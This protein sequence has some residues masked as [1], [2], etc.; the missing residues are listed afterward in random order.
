[1]RVTASGTIFDA[2][3]A[4]VNCRSCAFTSVARLADG[5]LLVA[6]RNAT[7]RDAPD[8]RLRVMRSRDT[9]AT[10]ETIVP[11]MTATVAGIEGNLYAGYLTEIAPAR[12]LGAF[13]WVDRSNPAL[14]FVNPV[15]TG[16]LPMRVLVA[17][18]PD[19]GETWGSFRTVDLAPHAGCSCTGPVMRLPGGR[20]ALPY[21]RWKEYDDAS[22]GEHG[23][24]LRFSGDG[25]G[26]WPGVATVATDPAARI[27]YWDQRIAVHPETGQLV[28]MFWTHD[29]QAEQDIETHIAWGTPD[30]SNWTVPRPTGWRGQHCEP[31]A[32][33]GDRLV[34]VYVHRHDPPS[35]RA[36]LS[37]DFGRSWL[38]ESEVVFYDSA[39]GTEAGAAG[40]RAFEDAWQDM[41][42]W[43]F[44]HPRGLLLPD[45]GLFVAY[46]AGDERATSVHWARLDI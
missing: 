31:I 32:A 27:C 2:N 15:T 44:G 35:L 19:G 8:G 6:F 37:D 14:S 17:E 5:T 4:P 3:A 13:V 21:E 16:V 26:T 22:P 45:G 28:A 7:G 34:A 46:Y 41:M 33:G 11:G 10:W 9:G 20:F 1:M 30:G 25:G 42:A 18:S 38:S 43:R 29:R 24:H 23:A 39:A 12:L 40:R 36:V